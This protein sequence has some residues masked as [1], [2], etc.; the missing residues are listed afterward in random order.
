MVLR[1]HDDIFFVLTLGD[2]NTCNIEFML[3]LHHA[4]LYYVI[5]LCSPQAYVNHVLTRAMLGVNH[6]PPLVLHPPLLYGGVCVKIVDW[7]C[8]L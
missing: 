6:S 7:L 4:C 2:S 8:L 1:L 5:W 3:T